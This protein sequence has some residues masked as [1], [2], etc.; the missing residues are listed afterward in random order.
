MKILLIILIS[1]ALLFMLLRL[2]FR[3][4]VKNLAREMIQGVDLVKLV[5]YKI[6]TDEFSKE[7][8]KEGEEFYKPLA[9]AIINEIFSCHN[10]KSR[11]VF[12]ENK[13]RVIDEIKKLGTNHPELK[14]PITDALRVFSQANFMLSG[15][16]QDN[17][18]EVFGNA[19]E[20]GLFIKGGEKPE[21]KSFLEMA[22]ELVEKYNVK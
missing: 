19:I 8:Q 11:L 1:I 7:Y 5:L 22:E 16:I 2:F 15:K 4:S 13:N 21:P 10:E 20:R 6:L 14:Q 9:A 17:F 3:S 18:Q 12:N